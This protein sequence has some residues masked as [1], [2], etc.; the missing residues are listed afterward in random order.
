MMVKGVLK[1]KSLDYHETFSHVI[2]MDV[3]MIH[4]CIGN[5]L[6]DFEI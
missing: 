6:L 2:Q 3:F 1:I 4:V 5:G